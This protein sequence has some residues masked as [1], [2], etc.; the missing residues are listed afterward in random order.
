MIIKTY[1]QLCRLPTF[2]ERYR[3]LRI[4]GIVGDETF[5]IERYLNQVFYRSKGWKSIRNEIIIRDEGCDLGVQGYEIEDRIYVH[6][7]NPITVSQVQ[8]ED[9]DLFNPEFLICTSF[10]THE[11]IHFGDESLLPKLPVERYPGDT[12]PWI[13]RLPFLERGCIK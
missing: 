10:N 12:C 6:H 11:A 13:N 7:I 2:E 3:Y 1:S 8:D 5:G 9:P 4:G